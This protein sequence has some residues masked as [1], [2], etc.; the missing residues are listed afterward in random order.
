MMRQIVL[1]KN[2][3]FFYLLLFSY[4]FGVIL[5]D[6]LEFDYTDEILALL[7]ILFASTTI[8]ERK[9][10]K[11]LHLLVWVIG[12]FSFYAIYSFLIRSNTPQAILMDFVIQIKPFLA[13][14]CAWIIAPK[15][16]KQQKKILSVVCLI[17]GGIILIAV[18]TENMWTFFGHPSRLATSATVTALLFFYCSSYSWSDIIAFI[19]LISISL[20]STRSK[21]YGFWGISVFL[22]IYCKVGGSLRLNIKAILALFVAVFISITLSWEK[23]VL[24]Y[25][26][27]MMNSEQMWSRPAM[28][29]TAFQILFDY[30]PFGSGFASFATYASSVHYSKIYAEYGIDHLYGISENWPSFITDAYYPELAQFGIVGVCLYVSFWVVIMRQSSPLLQKGYYKEFIIAVL[31]CAFFFIEGIADATFVHNRGVFI[32]ILLGLIIP[33]KSQSDQ[34]IQKQ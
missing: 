32:L 5:Y 19:I 14:Y 15:F 34:I 11:E 23:I 3:L 4:I 27:G 10:T 22:L 28:M 6:F 31:I 16:T 29:I 20:L 9:N 21:A 25:I 12:I 8:W 17:M 33:H 2:N 7:L 1:S 26:D 24:Y 30:F 18:V 13:F